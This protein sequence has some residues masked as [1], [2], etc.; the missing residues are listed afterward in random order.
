VWL[1]DIDVR[2]LLMMGRH[3]LALVLL[4]SACKAELA[5]APPDATFNPNGDSGVDASADAALGPWST[6]ML[7]TG[8]SGAGEQDDGTLSSSGLELVFALANAADANR[9]D[10]YVSTRTSTAVAFGMPNKLVFSV[11]GSSEETPRFSADDKTLYFASDR[12]GGA[13]LLDIYKTTRATI[14]GAWSAPA[15]VVGPNTAIA[16]KWFMPCAI[17]NDYLLIAGPDLAAGTVGGA[18]PTV[19]AELS[20][21]QAETGS[22]LSSDCLTAYF[23]SQRS[24]TFMIY[25]SHRT[26]L[27]APWQVPT[28]VVD[29]AGIGGAQEDPYLSA[30]GRTFVFVSN[31]GTTKDVYITTR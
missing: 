10:L 17:N 3:L 23:A 31:I 12:A 25:T 2:Y 16:E 11:V 24:G 15:L 21:V 7:V 27:A 20:S 14:G 1:P 28:A 19:V 6:P 30:D 5:N 29:F 18:A 22:F 4:C 8:A 9:K 13:G 26:S